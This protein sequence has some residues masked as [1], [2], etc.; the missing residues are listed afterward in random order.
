MEQPATPKIAPQ[1]PPKEKDLGRDFCRS[2][3][4][5]DLELQA[6]IDDQEKHKQQLLAKIKQLEFDAWDNEVK[7]AGA[8]A[9]QSKL[10]QL[11]ENTLERVNTLE[12]AM[13]KNCRGQTPTE[14]TKE[15]ETCQPLPKNQ[16]SAGTG[17]G[18]DAD[19]SESCASDGDEEEYL[20][21]PGGQTVKIS[22]DALRM[23]CRRLCETKPSGK[24]A[25]TAEIAQQF[26]AGGECREILEM[27]LLEAIGKHG[28]SRSVYKRVKADFTVKVKLIKEKMDSK[29]SEKYGRWMTE[30]AM[31]KS[32]LWSAASIKA[33][34]SYCKKF[35]ES[36]VRPFDVQKGFEIQKK[37]KAT[38]YA[39]QNP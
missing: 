10:Q 3:L 1:E 8:E 27:A 2:V 38:P 13:Q 26:R 18:K 12:S 32:G 25:V 5:A 20:T 6:K 14:P 33:I 22:A 17:H 11:L 16:S 37:K 15:R 39:N 9:N 30:E 4:H 31:R 7:K 24:C 23:R 34:I 35:P 36:L 29:E 19:G 28:L 21:T